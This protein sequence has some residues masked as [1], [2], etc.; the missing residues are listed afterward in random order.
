MNS[1]RE[2]AGRKSL[3]WA[4]RGLIA[5]LGALIWLGGVGVRR[6][7]AQGTSAPA[8][9]AASAQSGAPSASQVKI[10]SS[11]EPS[12]GSISGSVVG[13]DAKPVI[14]AQVSL[15]GQGEPAPQEV[16]TG[17]EGTFS[18]SNLAAGT[19]H[20]S[21]SASGF[22]P[23]SESITLGPGQNYAVS[24]IVLGLAPLV[25]SI[26]VTPSQAYM[27]KYQM[28][29]EEQQ[30]VLGFVPNY[31]VSYF[32]HTVPLSPKQKFELAAKATFTPF[33]LGLAVAT[34]GGEQA[35]NM[36]S[37]FG[38]G[39]QGYGKRFGALYASITINN[40]VG[41]ALLP[42]IL[43]QD[44]RFYYQ[45]NG[46][47]RSRFVYAMTHVVICKGDNGRWQP[48][49]SGILGHFIA[50]GISNLYY[51]PQ[52]RNGVQLTLENAAIGIGVHAAV[53]L[54]QEFVLPKFT[55]SLAKRHFSTP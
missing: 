27:A 9:P 48:D 54:L 39:M 55:P 22:K 26:T 50:S 41:D 46:S 47:V 11:V 8:A 29:E 45:G 18:F 34:A 4:A 20:L 16:E 28:Q 32:H 19:Y 23:Y 40:F 53:N 35:V 36:Y 5:G 17:T 14:G 21:I 30:L 37:G 1:S 12:A 7:D 52:N 51:P 33:V 2:A 42:S 13:E 25:T 44:P 15:A 49:Y 3:R 6:L 38:Q 31:Y 24:Q 43:K 10:P